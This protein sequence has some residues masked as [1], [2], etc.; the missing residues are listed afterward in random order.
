MIRRFSVGLI[1]LVLG[2]GTV[3]L[4]GQWATQTIPLQPGWSAVYLEVQPE[5]NDCDSIFKGMPIESV[6]AWN[7]RFSPVQFIQDPN[8]LLPGQPNWLTY[9][10]ADH[11]ARETRNLFTLRGGQTYLVKLK[12]G[13][14]ATT[15]NLS[16]Q[17]VVS[18]ARW[19][20]DSFNL[21]GFSVGGNNLPNFQA[22]FAGSPAHAGKPAYWLSAAGQW[23]LI[24]NPATTVLS[25]G[26][27]YWIYC[28][29]HSTYTGPVQ[30]QLEQ[31]D[32]LRYGRLLI[33][34]T[35]RIKNTSP[36]P[37]SFTV[38]PIASGNPADSRSPALAGAV[39]LSYFRQNAAQGE[40]SWIPLTGALQQT[41]IAPGEEWILRLEVNRNLMPEFVPSANSNG[42]LY[43]S[44]LEVS[45]GAGFRQLVPVSA[46]GLKTYAA[47]ASRASL[48]GSSQSNP[49]ATPHPR[50]GL[51]VGTAAI[52][53]VNQPAS[54]ATADLPSATASP[55][56]FRVILHVDNAGK[57]QLLQKVLQMFK[58]GT[59]KAN[60]D[61]PS[62]KIVDQ[63][64]RFVLVTDDA[65]IPRFSGA[66]LR[67]GQAVARRISSPAFGFAKP[68]ELTGAG[69]FGAG[70]LTCQVRID[71]DDPLNPFKHRYHPDHDNLDDR[72]E[73]KVP[74]GIESFTI[75]RRIELEFTAADPDQLAVAGWG[76]NQLGGIYRETIT[77]LHAKT[78]YALGS[79][80]LTQASRIGVLND[81]L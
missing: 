53:K 25:S 41:A 55:L 56:Q 18:S 30:L 3:P 40:F 75:T 66:T 34:Q 33:E 59:L 15:W 38:R 67:D 81:G 51:W 48:Q 60:P 52:Q 73:R 57:V 35:L 44:L 4:L 80:R 6:W 74:E 47:R 13:V 32:G 63:P 23:E 21:V 5:P 79:F 54:I 31:R 49:A 61:D 27:A 12:N 14:G 45:N 69:S 10:P 24:S 46:E 70:K 76:D 78:I 22:F 26:M 43:Q 9:L 29:G 7:Q 17:P 77:G 42:A 39:P 62:L 20:A 64:G 2:C 68:V 65:L 16:G 36:S 50:A 72:F 28:E 11:T 37:A 71:F 1:I 19:L 8:E 58:P